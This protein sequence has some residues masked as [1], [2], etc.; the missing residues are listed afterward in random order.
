MMSEV[1]VGDE[2]AK[3]GFYPADFSKANIMSIGLPEDTL[4]L[5]RGDMREPNGNTATSFIN[6]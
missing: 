2:S 5:Y 3:V 1:E 6:K 4:I